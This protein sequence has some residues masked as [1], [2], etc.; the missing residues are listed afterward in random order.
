MK[1]EALVPLI[2]LEGKVALVTGGSG[3]IGSAVVRFFLAAGAKVLSVDLPGRATPETDANRPGGA[4]HLSSDLTQPSQ[5]RELLAL[6]GREHGRLDIVVHSAGVTRDS[7]LWKMEDDAWSKVLA[8]NL[9]SAFYLLKEATPFL[10]TAGAGSVVLISSINGE[11]GKFGQANYAASKSGL[12]ALGMTAA[13]ELGRFNIRVNAVA[14]GWI[15]TPMTEEIPDEFRQRAVEE[16]PL[17]RLGEPD[18]VARVVLFLCSDLSRH[19]TGQVVRVD[20][21]QLMA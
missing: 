3:G 6:I 16:T 18:D 14:P 17:G 10:R 1:Q 13:L 21:G 20:G 15:E 4:I 7:V 5:V 9:D 19:V 8:V 12:I 11:R 2:S